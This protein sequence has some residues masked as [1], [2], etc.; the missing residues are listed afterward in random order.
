M[1]PAGS[2]DPSICTVP[3]DLGLATTFGSTAAGPMILIV[4][5]VPFAA[6]IDR[7]RQPIWSQLSLLGLRRPG[8]D[9][10]A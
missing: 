10:S 8:W 6:T 4:E 2:G 7:E 9:V 3:G 5:L 1:L